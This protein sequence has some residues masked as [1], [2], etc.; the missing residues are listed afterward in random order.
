M[1]EF[2]NRKTGKNEDRKGNISGIRE[3]RAKCA[4]LS[5]TSVHVFH[6]FLFKKALDDAS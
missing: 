2:F 1:T 5:K 3:N 4:T 6:V